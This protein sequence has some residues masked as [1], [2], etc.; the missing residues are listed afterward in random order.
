MRVQPLDLDQYDH[1]PT[2]VRGP[3]LNLISFPRRC[4]VISVSSTHVI[5]DHFS[6][7][8]DL[9]IPYNHSPTVLQAIEVSY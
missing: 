5:S 4:Y 3:S 6:F 7:V 1:F 9:K 2:H 8:A